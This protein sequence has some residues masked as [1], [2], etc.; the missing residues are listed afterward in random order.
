MVDLHDIGSV[1]RNSTLAVAAAAAMG[2]RRQHNFG[3][4]SP[5]RIDDHSRRSQMKR[6]L[7]GALALC[8]TGVFVI[9]LPAAASAAAHSADRQP[10]VSGSGYLALG[11]S[12]TFG[13][14]EA[15]VVP[16]PDYHNASSFYGYPE[17]L[18]TELRVKVAN[19]ACPG[20]TSS[21]LINRRPRA[22]AARTTSAPARA[23]AACTRC[24]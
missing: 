13:Y 9:T 6:R 17:L 15:Q 7:Y 22:T 5:V 24:T 8:A 21:S 19:A 10:V 12:V 16:A 4:R 14:Q 3:V 18:G 2:V 20:E 11:D 23:T 1:I